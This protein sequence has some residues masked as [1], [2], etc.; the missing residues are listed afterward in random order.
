MDAGQETT[1]S[2]RCG[3]CGALSSAFNV[4]CST[5]RA[6]LAPPVTRPGKAFLDRPEE[7]RL[8][9]PYRLI[10]PLGQG[11]FAPVW[12]AEEAYEGRKLRDVALKRFFAPDGRDAA[13]RWREDIVREA[14]AL[15]RV[16]H[17]NVVR[18]LSLQ[19]D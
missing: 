18:F 16:E 8:L 2:I 11:A 14:G 19:R 3:A 10:R 5:C 15:C 4:Q 13:A 1:G 12:L 7:T 9:G 6:P 17:P